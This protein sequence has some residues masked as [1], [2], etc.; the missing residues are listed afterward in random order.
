KDFSKNP[1][2]ADAV[3]RNLEIIGE[4]VKNM[5]G[6]IKSTRPNVPWKKIAGMRDVLI[7]EYYGVSLERVWKALENDLSKL[8]TDITNIKN[9]L[10]ALERTLIIIKPD[11]VRRKLSEKIVERYTKAGLKVVAQKKLHA[12]KSLLTK[13]YSAHVGKPFF[14]GL[15]RFMSS[16]EAIA[17]VLEGKNAVQEVRRITGVTDPSKADKGTIRGDFGIDSAEKA[18]SENRS[19]ENLVH[20]SGTPEEA[21]AEIKLWFPELH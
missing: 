19:I 17:C 1:M 6:T 4:A 16:G 2:V 10:T 3:I 18:N 12:D 13:H 5:P 8:K 15:L 21:R 14:E 11:G 20:A 7:H 9:S